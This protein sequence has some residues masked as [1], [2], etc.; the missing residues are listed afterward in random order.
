MTT[1]EL[2]RAHMSSR[3]SR[4]KRASD[5][6]ESNIM[7]VMVNLGYLSYFKIQYWF[8][9]GQAYFGMPKSGWIK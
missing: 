8:I 6:T 1:R 5:V 3:V 4:Y 9:Q 7:E 2:N